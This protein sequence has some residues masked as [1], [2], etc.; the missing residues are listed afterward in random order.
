MTIDT[1]KYQ[2][3]SENRAFGIKTTFAGG[4]SYNAA[5]WTELSLFYE[6][7]NN[8]IVEILNNLKTKHEISSSKGGCSESKNTDINSS[9]IVSEKSSSKFKNLKIIIEETSYDLSN[10]CKKK[11]N[12]IKKPQKIIIYKYNLKKE[13]YVL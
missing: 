7:N 8:E 5:R 2:L 10:N 3:N 12:I 13:K 6:N 9:V 1:T 11:L 4:N